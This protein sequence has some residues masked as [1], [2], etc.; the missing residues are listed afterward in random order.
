MLDSECE[1]GERHA[2]RSSD[3]PRMCVECHLIRKNLAEND[4]EMLQSRNRIVVR[5][6]P[7]YGSRL[8]PFDG[9]II[10]KAEES[11]AISLEEK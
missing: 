2:D 9:N 5:Q 10:N 8:K 3:D 6:S 1:C 11:S 7:V 4:P